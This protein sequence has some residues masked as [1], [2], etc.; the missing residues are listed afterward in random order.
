MGRHLWLG[1]L[2]GAA[3]KWSAEP[4]SLCPW[5][6]WFVFA[7]RKRE[8]VPWAFLSIVI[9][10][11]PGVVGIFFFFAIIGFVTV[12]RLVGKGVT[13]AEALHYSRAGRRSLSCK[14][15]TTRRRQSSCPCQFLFFTLPGEK[16]LFLKEKVSKENHLTDSYWLWLVNI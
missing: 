13:L 11:N 14:L 4:T 12:T 7:E 16:N 8:V 5:W 15:M 6:A 3:D 1:G 2:V 9:L 10:G